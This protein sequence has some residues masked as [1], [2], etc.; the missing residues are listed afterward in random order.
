MKKFLTLI[1]GIVCT[2]F[3]FVS[4]GTAQHELAVGSKETEKDL[5]IAVPVYLSSDSAIT[6]CQ[7]IVEYDA[8]KLTPLSP[9]V[10]GGSDNG[11]V[12]ISNIRETLPFVPEN[13]GAT[14]QILVQLSGGGTASIS[15]DSL[16]IAL[17][18][19]KANFDQGSTRLYFDSR[20]G[21]ASMT[22]IRAQDYTDGDL[23]LNAGRVYIAGSNSPPASFSLKSPQD[24]STGRPLQPSLVWNSA[25]DPDE[26]DTVTY[27]VQ[28]SLKQD[29][30]DVVWSTVIN[31]T[32][33]IVSKELAA[34]TEY[35]WRVV[36][37]DR[38]GA[39]TNSSSVFSFKTKN[40]TA[41]AS[42]KSSIPVAF[43]VLQN[44]PN[45]FNPAT[46]IRFGLP[47]Q[48]SVQVTVFN[49]A[50]REVAKI[51]N[52][53]FSAGWHQVV[54][55][56]RNMASGIYMYKVQAGDFVKTGKMNLLR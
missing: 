39:Q 25:I 55:D 13:A 35:F 40:T 45:P 16:E 53:R 21:R 33:A 50:G 38:V 47:N 19:F 32:N 3:V 17:L 48:S 10:E 24:G 46:T 5:K 51:A 2:A 52:G 31:D 8:A 6:F 43:Q 37:T 12:T 4:T 54:W 14:G 44:Y 34:A 18:N 20:S 15:G 56:A 22:S 42:P 23:K 27:L 29:F 1:A 7:F 11:G 36:A 41:V 26:N 28:L 9:F 49:M 30:Q